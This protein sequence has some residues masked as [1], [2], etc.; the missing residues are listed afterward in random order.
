M[1]QLLLQISSWKVDFGKTYCRLLTEHETRIQ[2]YR[3]ENRMSARTT[4]S[5]SDPNRSRESSPDELEFVII[6]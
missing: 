3:N 2:Y 5:M 6:T 4:T 1:E